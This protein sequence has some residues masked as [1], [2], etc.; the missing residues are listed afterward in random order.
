MLQPSHFQPVLPNNT[1]AASNVTKADLSR[2]YFMNRSPKTIRF[3]SL[4]LFQASYT[5]THTPSYTSYAKLNDVYDP[6]HTYTRARF[7]AFPRDTLWVRV[8]AN[9]L[10]INST[11]RN[12][13]RRRIKAALQEVFRE[14]GYEPNGKKLGGETDG[15]VGTLNVMAGVKLMAADWKEVKKDANY[16]VTR[17]QEMCGD[18]GGIRETKT[19]EGAQKGAEKTRLKK[20]QE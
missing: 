11:I 3:P 8:N 19:G 5:Y 12:R 9:I 1:V 6:L 17:L 4:K 2:F 13:Y 15:F 18:G 10:Q 16:V 7:L 14:K 20:G